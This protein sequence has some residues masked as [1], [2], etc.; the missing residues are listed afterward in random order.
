MAK[1]FCVEGISYYDYDAVCPK[2]LK[3]NYMS[4]CSVACPLW[5]DDKK[6]IHTVVDMTATT[7][8]R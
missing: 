1:M 4:T 5:T 6:A 3:K 2:N 7:T 8:A